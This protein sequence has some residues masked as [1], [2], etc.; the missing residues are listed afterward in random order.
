MNDLHTEVDRLLQV[1]L[2]WDTN[3]FDVE[4]GQH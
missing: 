4:E 1:Q 3:Q 2:A